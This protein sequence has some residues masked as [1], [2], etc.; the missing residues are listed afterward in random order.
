MY[1]SLKSQT[2]I[3][4]SMEPLIK[5][6]ELNRKGVLAQIEIICRSEL[7]ARAP[8]TQRLLRYISESDLEGRQLTESD[9][10][11]G[12]FNK[13]SET[14]DPKTDSI[15]RRSVGILREK[16]A[17]YYW[18]EGT[19]DLI[20][21]EIPHRSFNISFT[22]PAG[23]VTAESGPTGSPT[24]PL[25]YAPA[26]SHY[27]R[28]DG[29]GLLHLPNVYVFWIRDYTANRLFVTS[30]GQRKVAF[31]FGIGHWNVLKKEKSKVSEVAARDFSAAQRFGRRSRMDQ[32]GCVHIP[33]GIRRQLE[34]LHDVVEVWLHN[35]S[36]SMRS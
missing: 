9:I 3:Y 6:R 7:F 23:D 18:V 11:L 1:H 4:H 8:T 12:F 28:L 30:L 29:K 19:R 34:L 20:V 2:H 14:Y 22:M 32:K 26:G 36:W 24:P 31:I 35:E 27:V 17:Q 5:A 16:L 21:M 33:I 10:A 13:S 15:G 25:I